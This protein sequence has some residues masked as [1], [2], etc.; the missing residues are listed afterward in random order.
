MG[1]TTFALD[2]G[3]KTGWALRK[4]DGA[5]VSGTEICKDPGPEREGLRYLHFRRWLTEIKNSYAGIDEVYFEL[6][7]AHTSTKS[8][9]VYGGLKAILTM[10]CAHHDIYCK[11]I[12]VGTIKKHATG[13]G[14][15]EKD[16]VIAAMKAKGFS[17]ADD[18]E[19]DAIALL[20]CAEDRM[21]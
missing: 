2:L 6:V 5:I 1:K 20:L 19:A 11:G 7:A 13:K 8:A 14:N 10:W 18:N 17:P 16:A 15:A 4:G 21:A 9:H 3:T 12:P